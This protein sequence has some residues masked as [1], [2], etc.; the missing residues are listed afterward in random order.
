MAIW[1]PSLALISHLFNQCF[2]NKPSIQPLSHLF[3]RVQ[4]RGGCTANAGFFDLLDSDWD[5]LQRHPLSRLRALRD[6]P[7]ER[8]ALEEVPV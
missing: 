4:E 2:P 5:L 6:E 1:L 3:N 8:M 7:A